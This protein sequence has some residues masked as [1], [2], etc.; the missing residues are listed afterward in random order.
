M[1]SHGAD[2]LME[3]NM[4]LESFFNVPS[5][6]SPLFFNERLIDGLS[7]RDNRASITS[8]PTEHTLTIAIPG[9]KN[10][11]ISID[12]DDDVIRVKAC[13]YSDKSVVGYSEFNSSWVFE[14]TINPTTVKA[15]YVAGILRIVIPIE[16]HSEKKTHRIAIT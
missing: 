8:S 3:V 2:V 11:D 7:V 16:A 4:F 15:T 13:A 14:N 6:R 5:M 1:T 12:V 9:R 10:E